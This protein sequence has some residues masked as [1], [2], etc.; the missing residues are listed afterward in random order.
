MNEVMYQ[1]GPLQGAE[2]RLVLMDW[3]WLGWHLKGEF[4]KGQ[5]KLE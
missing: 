5:N 1:M 3:N 4:K 2:M